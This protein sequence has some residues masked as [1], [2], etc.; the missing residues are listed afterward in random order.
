MNSDTM[1]EATECAKETG[2]ITKCSNCYEHRAANDEIAEQKAVA[3]ALRR[4]DRQ[5]RGFRGMSDA[6]VR[7]A[8]ESAIQD[9][10]DCRCRRFR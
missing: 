6:E 3:L 7:E 10:A 4:R 2:A 5:H 8:V 1:E 9:T